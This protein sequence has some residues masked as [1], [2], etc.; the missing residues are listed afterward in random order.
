[1]K[2]KKMAAVIAAIVMLFACTSFAYAA[3]K[4]ITLG[5]TSN[6]S[7][8]IGDTLDIKADGWIQYTIKNS[9]GST[10]DTGCSPDSSLTPGFSDRVSTS[11]WSNGTYTLSYTAYS[12]TCTASMVSDGNSVGY[13]YVYRKGNYAGSGKVTITVKESTCSHTWNKVTTKK[14]T[15]T[16]SGLETWTCTKCGIET[17][18][19]I[20]ATGHVNV[21]QSETKAT[22][23]SDG[24]VTNKCSVCGV[25]KTS[26]VK[27]YGHSYELNAVVDATCTKE[28]K[29]T[30][31]C[32]RCGV[33]EDVV[34][35]A[36]GHNRA[37]VPVI[38]NGME[39]YRCT[40]CNVVLDSLEIKKIGSVVLDKDIYEYTGLR[41]N[42]TI[43]VYS[44]GGKV[45]DESCYTVSVTN[46]INR[47]IATVK[48]TGKGEY[49][50]TAETTFVI[51]TSI[52][53][54][55]FSWNK[56]YYDGTAKIP[57]GLYGTY[58][59]KTLSLGTDFTVTCSDNTNAGFGIMKITGKGQYFG[60]KEVTFWIYPQAPANIKAAV[61]QKTGVDIIWD[62]V[63]CA[64]SYDVYRNGY[65]IANV[66][67]E[68]YY[69]ASARNNVRYIYAVKA[70]AAK[71]YNGKE[72]TA[73]SASSEECC[74]TPSYTPD[75]VK[76]ISVV[77]KSMA[78]K[79]NL[80]RKP[81][82]LNATGYE[83]RY[84]VKESSNWKKVTTTSS[85]KTIKSLKSGK[86][87]TVQVRTYKKGVSKTYY[88]P[89]SASKTVSVR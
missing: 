66:T 10:I 61:S 52:S 77:G 75:K 50:G 88:G 7:A 12:Q 62:A 5:V 87:Y 54:A 33:S 44:V 37:S 9:S 35:P 71:A 55:T 39:V 80:K 27:A 83:I 23:T 11:G 42:P 84:K 85:A 69:D 78:L 25:V 56:V 49:E 79:V 41:I 65:K 21:V 47:G 16:A 13:R 22:C 73:I 29:G 45:L 57:E 81:A 20:P 58:N 32:T 15:C 68:Y 19:S 38:E 67:S 89:Y 18:Y 8:T 82:L 4:T 36:Y 43:C 14:S 63:P 2:A 1:M 31:K 59:G 48:V 51:A 3:T 70:R 26:T 53:N 40:R 17:Y 46:N 86:R 60:T 34:I 30:K 28:G 74:I 72:K 64:S 6:V 24:S 76:S